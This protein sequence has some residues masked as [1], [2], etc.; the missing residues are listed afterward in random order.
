M[1]KTD[2]NDLEKGPKIDEIEKF[3]ELKNLC[4]TL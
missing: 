4:K 1:K 2:G 3:E